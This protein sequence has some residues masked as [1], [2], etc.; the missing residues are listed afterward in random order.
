MSREAENS[1]LVYIKEIELGVGLAWIG[2][3]LESIQNHRDCPKHHFVWGDGH[4]K[5]RIKT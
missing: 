5:H 2:D 1:D 3:C 4:D